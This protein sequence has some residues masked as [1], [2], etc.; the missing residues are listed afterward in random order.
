MKYW[1]SLWEHW[2]D[3]FTAK[4]KNTTKNNNYFIEGIS[5]FLL[6]YIFL[7]FTSSKSSMVKW[8]AEIMLKTKNSIG[9]SRK[10]TSKMLGFCLEC[11]FV[12]SCEIEGRVQEEKYKIFQI[13]APKTYKN[14]VSQ[15]NCHDF[16]VLKW[17]LLVYQD[18]NKNFSDFQ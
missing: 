4:K 16:F 7:L 5:L 18:I 3:D 15:N 8:E 12:S 6:Y 1:I 17:L 2:K 14:Y 13:N 11:S 9:W 10:T